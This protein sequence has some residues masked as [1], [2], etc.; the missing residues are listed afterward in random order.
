MFKYIILISSI[1][2]NS[3]PG[4]IHLLN[5]KETENKIFMTIRLDE[6][7]EV[8]FSSYWDESRP[9]ELSLPNRNII[10][11]LPFNK[12]LKIDQTIKKSSNKKFIPRYNPEVIRKDSVLE[13]R[14]SF[15][16]S[17][18]VS[19]TDPIS[20]NGFQWVGNIYCINID[21]HQCKYDYV[22]RVVNQINEL[23][24][25]ITLE[26]TLLYY[27]DIQTDEKY[28]YLILNF[29]EAVK[30]SVQNPLTWDVRSDWID[31]DKEYIKLKTARDGIYR[32]TYEDLEKMNLNSLDPARINIYKKGEKIPLYIHGADDQVFNNG[33]YIEFY[34]ERNM[35]GRHRDISK[36]NE[37]YN[38]YLNR[39]TDTTVYWLSWTDN[40]PCRVKLCN[41]RQLNSSDTL[42]YY[43]E[44]QHYEKDNWF[45]YSTDQLVRRELPYWIENKTW[46]WHS[47]SL[48]CTN[49]EFT[50]KD[51]Y[52]GKRAQI[53]LKLQSYASSVLVNSHNLGLGINDNEIV[54]LGFMNKYEQKVLNI[55]LNSNDL[56][57][58]KN[59]I[60][61]YSYPTIS[62]I[63][64][65]FMDWYEIE[66]PRELMLIN[67]S[68][69]FCF[70]YLEEQTVKTVLLK[71]VISHDHL[72]WKTGVDFFRYSELHYEN[73][74]LV[75]CDTISSA[76]KFILIRENNYLTPVLSYPA[77][78]RDLKNSSIQA[79]YIL[80]TNSEFL[81]A[82]SEYVGFI[83]SSY[84]V[85]TIVVDVE[86]IYNVYNYGYTNP[87][88][89]KDFL[90][91]SYYLWKK[92]SPE[93][94][95][96]VG[97]G[98]YD[99]HRIKEINLGSP[100]VNC[101][102]P[103][104][105]AP[106]SD[107]W[108]VIWDT[109]GACIPMM[110]IGR[111]PVSTKN[112]FYH[113]FT[114]HRNYLK[115][116]FSD[117]N[118]RFMFFSGGMGNNQEELDELKR[119]NDLVLHY[120]ENLPIAG[121]C[122]HFF[123]TID[124]RSDYGPLTSQQIK[125]SI[126]SGAVIISYLGHSG[127][128]TW[129]NGIVDPRQ[130]SNSRNKHPLV[131]DFGCS[132][133]KFAEPD[134]TSF[135]EMFINKGDA[136]AYLGNSS[137]GFHSTSTTFPL[138]F[139][140]L[141]LQDS[142]YRISDAHKR[143]KT[144]LLM[145][146]GSSAVYQLFSLT[147]T[148]FGDPI[149][150]LPIPAKPDLYLSNSDVKLSEAHPSDNIDSINIETCLFNLGKGVNDS[151]NI[152]MKNIYAENIVYE[153]TAKLFIPGYR[154]ALTLG[155]PVKGRSG[156]HLVSIQADPDNLIDEIYEDNNEIR[157]KLNVNNSALRVLDNYTYESAVKDDIE[158]ISPVYLPDDDYT[159]EYSFSEDF[160]D[161][162]YIK[163]K[164]GTFNSILN[165]KE[166]GSDSRMWIRARIDGQESYSLNKS[167]YINSDYNC[168]YNDSV[169]FKSLTL[170]NLII[171]DNRI[172][173]NDSYTTFSI[174]SGGFH[175]G[176]TAVISKDGQTYVPGGNTIGH[177]ICVFRE[178]T[179]EFIDY[180]RFNVFGGT[181]EGESY[182]RYL[183]TISS[184]YLILIGVNDEG[185]VPEYLKRKLHEFGS[186]YIDSLR[187]RSSWAFMGR[188][189]ATRGSV[190]E[191]FSHPFEGM[192]V[193][194]T[195]IRKPLSQGWLS[196]TF[197]GPVGK[198]EN[199]LL[200]LNSRDSTVFP[201]LITAYSKDKS[202]D[203]VIILWENTGGSIGFI[204]AAVY[205]R[206]KVRRG[207]SG[208]GKSS[209]INCLGIKYK[210]PPELVVTRRGAR[211]SRDTLEWGEELKLDLG[212][213]NA[214]EISSGEFLV[215]VEVKGENDSGTILQKKIP[216]IEPKEIRETEFVINCRSA[217][218]KMLQVNAD[219]AG[220]VDEI[221]E[222]NNTLQ[223]PFYVKKDS[224][225]PD[226]KITFD[227]VDVFD[228][229]YVSGHPVVKILVSD[230]S[231]S[232]ISPDPYSLMIYTDGNYIPPEEIKYTFAEKVI[233]AE[234]SPQ[235]GEGEHIIK[236]AASD[237]ENNCKEEV[238]CVNVSGGTLLLSAYNYPN[239]F[240]R[241]TWF[242]FILTGIP[243]ELLIKIYTTAGRLIRK[244]VVDP[245]ELT[246][247]F[248]R[249]Y[250]D[251]RDEEGNIAANGIYFY[252]IITRK[253]DKT[254][255]ITGKLAVI[256]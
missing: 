109:T 73:D 166:F 63:N 168:L 243:D 51:V 209:F 136:I 240:S 84:N 104:F 170:E 173:L 44:I 146:F 241:E 45:D 165:L 8:S 220:E 198:W 16:K 216:S 71:N 75:F 236:I 76:D 143:A 192:A 68:L 163:G 19:E 151:V 21:I 126:D 129:D 183:D 247:D 174:I 134:V 221:Y 224:R 7:S 39:Y 65:L 91:Y 239:P 29:K 245:G 5:Y 59:Q 111:I 92:P 252:K 15:P 117:W 33:D 42:K 206:I 137:L 153:K 177:H 120:A 14:N 49:Y 217:G 214:G 57:E 38:E 159:F 181:P 112:E 6:F 222:D 200:N 156:E 149:I 201:L 115:D 118:K 227:G 184:D 106:V 18:L 108:F 130:L 88:V 13:Y 140:R 46:G 103:S 175:D 215:S 113:Y 144:E 78:I 179:H 10:I 193:I 242:T 250:W 208:E 128:Q 83:E 204:D 90:Q 234:F 122:I 248:N 254:G 31:Y 185:R 60:K 195:I 223:I 133:G 139:F 196:T 164:I 25:I 186:I 110:N 34:G 180:K 158:I 219:A 89:I 233:S 238:L 85:K 253:G 147:N 116:G 107:N 188:R 43:T 218:S 26:D 202:R 56:P 203:T 157:F 52:L 105:G 58:G 87:E 182:Y 55:S 131:T 212:I 190:P 187:F 93:F 2:I 70:G 99:Y 127:T 231:Y 67:D 225:A 246:R 171:E 210:L 205:P 125:N 235:L 41:G 229:S 249:V 17:Q 152:Y 178:D 24:I 54:Q 155:L 101:I 226:I 172:K 53:F 77:K 11:G 28:K 141:M 161:T 135:A 150:S 50:T 256:K 35:G 160:K 48:G 20:I 40:E 211:L 199:I 36:Y 251:G 47:I 154:S 197:I 64:T 80:I 121:Y 176:K 237:P 95:F 1:M 66:Y 79:D 213:Y 132:T 194:D 4:Q 169:S 244:I 3:V 228:G 81:D 12:V 207:L 114:K 123:K 22:Q 32:I 230:L 167:L 98:T 119:V 86:D 30:Y 124:P 9:A 62:D 162:R 23:E 148:L 27:A 97:D 138:I 69:T 37:P 232:S 100:R 145:N 189:G 255:N 94:V 72:I 191:I 61:L 102:V 142:V 96:I 74:I 82:A